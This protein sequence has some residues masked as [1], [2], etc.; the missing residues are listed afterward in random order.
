M[1]KKKKENDFDERLA[2]HL[3]VYGWAYIVLMMTIGALTHFG[4]FNNHNNDVCTRTCGDI[5]SDAYDAPDENNM[6]IYVAEF[7]D[8]NCN[9]GSSTTCISWS[10]K[11]KCEKDPEADGCVCDEQEKTVLF[12]NGDGKL[13]SIISSSQ[14]FWNG[15]TTDMNVINVTESCIRAH[16]AVC[17]EVCE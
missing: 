10:P 7:D 5:L 6:L 17:K 14:E 3:M 12:M 16:E 4:F 9:R 2:E 1:M 11:P 8:H 13:V 15:V